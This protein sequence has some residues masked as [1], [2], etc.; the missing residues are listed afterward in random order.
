MYFLIENG[1]I[2]AI[3]VSFSEATQPANLENHPI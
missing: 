2:P 3:Y 1:D